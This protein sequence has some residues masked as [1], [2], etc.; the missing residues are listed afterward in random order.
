MGPCRIE[1]RHDPIDAGVPVAGAGMIGAAYAQTDYAF[2][3]APRESVFFRARSFTT[4]TRLS[5]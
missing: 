5:C 3:A 1:C 2:D 4:F